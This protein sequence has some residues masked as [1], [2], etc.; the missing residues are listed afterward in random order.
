MNHSWFSAKLCL[1]FVLVLC[2]SPVADALNEPT[3]ELVSVQATELSSLDKILREQLGMPK[4]IQTEFV[5]KTNTAVSWIRLGG[6]REDE[7]TY[8]EY[9]TGKARSFRHF[10]D[11]LLAWDRS[12]LF[13]PL[14][15]PPR[16]TR[17]ESSI[18]WAQRSDQDRESGR[19][20]FSWLDARR[21][22]LTALTEPNPTRREQ[23]FA[24]T[25]RALGQ[26]MHLISDASVPEHVRND[27]HPMATVQDKFGQVGNYEYWVQAQ[28]MKAGT[29]A[30]FI[31]DYL[32]TPISLDP[33]LLQIA[34][35][36]TETIARLPIAR[37]FDSDRYTGSNPDVTAESRIGIAETANA[38]FVSPGT[39][40]G[41]YPH[42][43]LSNM[44]KYVGT[45]SK[46][47]EKRSYYRKEGAG[48]SVDPVAAEC[49]LDEVTGVVTFCKDDDVWR[50]TARHM[51]PRAVRYGQEVLEYFFRG[52][53]EVS[54]E[55]DPE[56][57]LPS[58]RI[59]NRSPEPLGE[60][61]VLTLYQDNDQG[62]RSSV[63]GATLTLAAA[64]P[65]D[66]DAEPLRLPVPAYLPTGGLTLVYQGPLGLEQDA[67]IGKIL[68]PVVVEEVYR[69]WILNEWILRT[70]DGLYILP[71]ATVAGLSAPPATVRWGDLDNQLVAVT[72]AAMGG[73]GELG[74]GPGPGGEAPFL[75]LLFELD[76]TLG[77][78]QVPTTGATASGL[79]V[80]AIRLVRQI[81]LYEVLE[82]LNLNTTV[83][84][85]GQLQFA[86]YMPSWEAITTCR[87]QDPDEFI[88]NY[89]C[90]STIGG[91]SL[92]LVKTWGDIV[93]DAFPLQLTRSQHA[94]PGQYPTSYRWSLAEV[95]GDR[96]NRLVAMVKVELGCLP[97]EITSWHVPL[98][99]VNSSG[100][101][102]E[103]TEIARFGGDLFCPSLW[104]WLVVDLT[105][106]RVLAKSSADEIIFQGTQRVVVPP[107][108]RIP[109]SVLEQ[110]TY[111]GGKA[112]GVYAFRAGGWA[113][114]GYGG[115]ITQSREGPLRLTDRGED[116]L[117]HAEGFLRPSLATLAL[118]DVEDQGTA[119][120][121]FT[122]LVYRS[123]PDG[124]AV[125]LRVP[126]TVPRS[127]SPA[128][129]S[130]WMQWTGPT[131]G[132][133][134][135][136]AI[137]EISPS[138][139]ENSGGSVWWVNWNLNPDTA[140][141]VYKETASNPLLLLTA[142]ASGAL[143]ARRNENRYLYDWYW[144]PW[145]GM[146]LALELPP[147]PAPDV[148][149]GPVGN[150]IGLDPDYIYNVTTGHF[151]VLRPGLPEQAG[152]PPLVP[153]SIPWAQ[154]TYHVVGR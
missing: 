90:T 133:L 88:D 56:T 62:E 63:Q 74:G 107:A 2:M 19:G 64:V 16:I 138:Q 113:T 95:R 134:R 47:G 150:Y 53:L 114:G 141:L 50:A 40:H 148:E 38:N 97:P 27:P 129:F 58:L 135:F 3:H 145:A 101:L 126:N 36:S 45:Y 12:G 20:N 37:L 115:P 77:T 149:F 89:M 119:E 118:G 104:V 82:G 69:D 1:P 14:T 68:P 108:G 131:P 111:S 154:G 144:I 72:G 91:E 49:V 28:H 85:T 66:N 9:L 86:Q 102:A 41:E 84:F 147:A 116:R 6:A 31:R 124:T 24:D 92:P 106:R 146:P 125:Y 139:E 65:K 21:Y 4:G 17:F 26:V 23:A 11:P 67:V 39:G 130:H 75:A 128:G 122:R 153:R 152:P 7:S 61:G 52:K 51:L 57:G 121:S 59:V 140:T 78:L 132:R 137:A 76:R 34:I 80:A 71:L 105:E 43:A 109:V 98:L 103:S 142:N 29:E 96:A 93:S 110:V 42:P 120:D 25:F 81:D 35:S 79:P 46:V 54:R 15:I 60:G 55:P 87:D 48:L 151:H 30:A 99:E 112:D 70:K 44:P 8:L 94:L 123:D 136:E 18:R 83:Q 10:H 73:G 13:Y 22:F 33:E 143:A 127:M 5:G 32:S 117:D 100:A